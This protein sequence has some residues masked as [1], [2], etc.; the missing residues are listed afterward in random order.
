[1]FFFCKVSEQLEPSS[2]D[3]ASGSG[4]HEAGVRG[5]DLLLLE[6]Q[7]PTME[8]SRRRGFPGGSDGKESACNAGDMGSIPGSGLS[9]GEGNGNPLNILAWEIPW[10]EEPGR[11]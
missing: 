5:L 2:D 7:N 1:M 10:T 6:M 8:C 11:L 9:P 3:L 4:V